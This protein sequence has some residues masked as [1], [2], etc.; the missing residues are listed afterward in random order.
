MTSKPAAGDHVQIITADDTIQGT[1]LPRPE[2]LSSDITVVKLESGYNLGIRND[3][4]QKISVKKK[5]AAPKVTHATHTDNPELPTVALLSFGGTISS[6][7][8]YKSGGVIADYNADDFIAMCP[9]IAGIAN[10]RAVSVTNVMSEDFNP[11]IWKQMAEETQAQLLKD[12][13]AGVVITHGTDT[14]HY[15]AA[16]LSFMLQ[17]LNKPVILTASQRSIDRGS[18]DAFMNLICAIRAAAEFD[19]AVVATCMHGTSNDDYCTLVRGTKVRKMHTSRRD[20]FQPVNDLPLAKI[21]TDRDIEILQ[22]DYPHRDMDKRTIAR[23]SFEAK[24][25]LL[26]VYPGMDE[27]LIDYFIKNDYKGLVVSA[28]AL[29]HVPTD[30]ASHNIVGALQKAV[31][32][33]VLVVIA[34]QTLYGR[35]HPHVYTNLRKISIG[36][37]CLFSED[38]TPETAYVKLGWSLGQSKNTDESKKLFSTNIAGE[39]NLRIQPDTY[40]YH[41]Q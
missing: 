25:G 34:S 9:E 21:W 5:Y 41:D 13:I 23:T 14:L 27:G 38:M 31:K 24:T 28:T 10:V 39:V 36:A 15:S 4:I 35:T 32:K 22:T 1:L 30:Q 37:G 12:D 16:A 17:D 8:D 20:A 7:I 26:Q 3:R 6:R 29:G 33:G 2:M 40:L 18:S 19:G 11:T